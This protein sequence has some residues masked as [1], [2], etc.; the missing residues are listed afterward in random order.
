M[1]LEDTKIAGVTILQVDSIEDERGSFSRIFCRD[2]LA[3]SGLDFEVFQ[4]NVSFNLLEE[5]LRGLHYQTT[6]H[7]EPKIILCTQ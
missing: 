5:T 7:A 6:P 2:R 3:Q 1:N 4:A